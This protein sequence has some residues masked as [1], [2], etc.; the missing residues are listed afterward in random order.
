MH[1]TVT[2]LAY[3]SKNRVNFAY[4]NAILFGSVF[5]AYFRAT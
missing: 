3:T 1:D 2:K 5:R 4:T